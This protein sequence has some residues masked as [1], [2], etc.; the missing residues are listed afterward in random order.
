[1][2][3]LAFPIIM[4]LI[5]LHLLRKGRLNVD[6]SGSL[7]LALVA[8][9][10]LSTSTRALYWM[11][12]LMEINYVPLAIVAVA[13]GLLL[14]SVIVL[15]VMVSDNRKRQNLIL[16]RLAELELSAGSSSSLVG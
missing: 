4:C 12:E 8:V 7:I 10:A 3:K 2:V 1:M 15:A 6:L 9:M 14:A 16:R 11:A 13:I 5:V